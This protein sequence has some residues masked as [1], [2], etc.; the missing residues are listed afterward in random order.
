MAFE[1]AFC[2]LRNGTWIHVIV[3][4]EKF[5]T[6]KLVCT[7]P[8]KGGFATLTIDIKRGWKGQL[9]YHMHVLGEITTFPSLTM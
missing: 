5:A 6:C 8:H 4:N 7:S 3:G 1:L 2:N 9:W